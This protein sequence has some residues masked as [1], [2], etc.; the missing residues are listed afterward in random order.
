MSEY[1]ILLEE[2]TKTK[3]KWSKRL[4]YQAENKNERSIHDVYL[5]STVVYEI[6]RAIQRAHNRI[7][8]DNF[9]KQIMNKYI[10]EV[11]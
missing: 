2:L 4:S 7:I 10:K 9:S 11:K 6:E 1:E 5:C 3:D 8:N